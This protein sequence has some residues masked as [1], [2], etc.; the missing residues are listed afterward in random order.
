MNILRTL[1]TKIAQFVAPST[2]LS[3]ITSKDLTQEATTRRATTSKQFADGEQL[4][5][6]GQQVPNRIRGYFTTDDLEDLGSVIA[7]NA[8][9]NTAMW[10]A[11]LGLMNA[12]KKNDSKAQAT[13]C[14]AWAT[15]ASIANI[16]VTDKLVEDLILSLNKLSG[17][18]P[19][20][21]GSDETDAIIARIGNVSIADLRAKREA[22]YKAEVEAG[23]EHVRTALSLLLAA[24]MDGHTHQITGEQAL[25]SLQRAA[26]WVAGWQG[27][28]EELAATLLIL[29]QDINY[30]RKL[31][32]ERHDQKFVDGI[33]AVDTITSR[34]D[35]VDRDAELRTDADQDEQDEDTKPRR[36][37]IRQVQAE[38][39]ALDPLEILIAREE[40]QAA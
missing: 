9:A 23:K 37:R 35:N 18:K 17:G 16:Q 14:S 39:L 26:Q 15:W 13:A 19:I 5:F 11:Q 3:E 6:R 1:R 21:H 34:Y 33:M 10:W 32:V 30:V 4:D 28:P 40:Q 36:R 7:R 20:K 12:L 22:K 24:D 38:E 27:E 2:I 29:E 25:A 31:A 8:V